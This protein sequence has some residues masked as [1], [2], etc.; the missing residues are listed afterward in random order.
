MKGLVGEMISN[1][2]SFTKDVKQGEDFIYL[3]TFQFREV[4]DILMSNQIYV[5]KMSKI[6]FDACD[7]KYECNI[8]FFNKVKDGVTHLADGQAPVYAVH[9]LVGFQRWS[10]ETVSTIPNVLYQLYDQYGV[11]ADRILLELKVPR[12]LAL[13]FDPNYE[14]DETG[15]QKEWSDGDRVDEF[16]LQALLPFIKPEWLICWYSIEES[17]A[18]EDGGDPTWTFTPSNSNG[19]FTKPFSTILAFGAKLFEGAGHLEGLDFEKADLY[20]E[21]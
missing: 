4:L 13:I 17:S 3:H 9:D 7:G 1:S 12:R 6:Y 15:I 20:S 11:R 16:G 19:V 5:A 14:D 8:E 10:D 2:T 18:K 21:I